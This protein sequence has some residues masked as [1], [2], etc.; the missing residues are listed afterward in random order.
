MF[1]FYFV[2]HHLL[3]SF[4]DLLKLHFSNEKLSKNKE[5]SLKLKAFE[6]KD[7]FALKEKQ[8]CEN[9]YKLIIC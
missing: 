3:K 6:K 5:F 7:L 8:Y 2:Y 4:Q 1:L 9:Y